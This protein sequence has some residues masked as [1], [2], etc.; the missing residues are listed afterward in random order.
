MSLLDSKSKAYDKLAEDLNAQHQK[1][2]EL[3]RQVSELEQSV[4][5]ANAAASSSKFH[6]QGLQQEIEQLKR[7]NDW[8]DKELKTKSEEYSKYR[9]EKGLRISELQR[10]KED[11][12]G[13]IESLRKTETNL[14]RRLEELSEKTDNAFQKIQQMEEAAARKDES[15]RIELDAAARLQE[16]TRKSANTEQQR[17]QDLLAELEAA[18]D[19]A[20]EQLGKLG[21]E[22]ET[23][24]QEREA[25]EA[26]IAELEVQVEHL[27][28]DLS[29]LGDNR[30]EPTTPRQGVNGLGSRT[31]LRDGA[32][33]GAFSPG[34]A[35]IKGG[36]S[37]T[38]MYS[39]YNDTARQLDAEKRRNETLS[40]TIDAMIQEMEA[41]GPEIEEMQN[42]HG[43][44]ETEVETLSDLVN[45]IGQDRDQATKAV[46][47]WESQVKVKTTEGEVLRQQLRDLS[48]QI[49]VLLMEAHIRNHENGEISVEERARLE[50]IARGE[51]D[52]EVVEGQSA[53]A[54]FINENLVI[55]RD[56][57]GLQE[58]NA[59]LLKI[60]REVGEKLENEDALRKQTEDARNWEDLQ[61][62]YERCKDEIKSLATQSQSYIRERD[63]FRRMLAHRGQIPR[64]AESMFDESINV[65]QGTLEPQ[66]GS[67]IKSTEDVSPS[68]N[69]ADYAKL[70]KD[71]QSHFD[72]YK[73]EAATDNKTL[74]DQLD[75]VSKE[76]S[77]L[78]SEAARSNSQVSLAHERYEMLQS[79]YGMLKNENGELQKRAQTYSDNA[80]KQDLRVQ[81]VAE[82]LVE[83]RG[84]V[85]SMRNETANLKAEKEFWKS[86]EKRITDDNESLLN[87]R[88]RLNS[89]NANLQNLLNEREHSDSDTRRRLHLQ[90]ESLE[91]DLQTTKSKLTEETE[92]NKRSTQRR[93][94]DQEQNQKRIDDLISSLGSVR[95]ELVATKTTRDH[96]SAR[97]DELT[98]EL[99]SAEERLTVLHSAS[100]RDVEVSNVEQQG[101]AGGDGTSHLTQEQELG[102][103][104]S[105][106]KRDLD[107]T[108]SALD[109]AHEQVEQY[110]SISQ[111]S[112]DELNSM[113]E[114][115]DL[116]RQ[117]MEKLIEERDTRIKELEQRVDD[118]SS[119]LASSNDELS[120]LRSEQA[121][122]SRRLEEHKKAF[123]AE[124]ALLKD[125]DDR[126]AAAAQYY[127]E[128]LK[129][130]A[131]IAQ[132]AQ[133]NYE[134]EL[135]K[136]ADAAKAL[137]KVRNDYNIL[138]LE[139][140]EVKT[141]AESAKMNLSQS[142]DSWTDS[143]ERFEREMDELKLARQDLKIQ[144]EFLHKQLETFNTR[145]EK[146]GSVGDEETSQAMMAPG[147]DNLQEVI[148][149]LRREKEIVDV[150]FELSSQEAKRLR[151]QLDYTQSQLDENR[152]KLN[153]Q[154]RIEA[155]NERSALD[156]TKLMDTINDLNT[157]RES[158]VTLRAE[159]R[160]A[161]ATVAARTQEIEALRAQVEP[162]QAQVRELS[163]R[164][165]NYDGEAKLLKENCDRWQQRAQNVLQKYDRVDPADLES[166]KEQLKKAEIERDEMAASKQT[167][168]DQYDN[169]SAQVD[170]E[171]EQS[172]ERV[173]TMKS[174]LTEQFKT[175][176]K[177]LSERIKE[178]DVALQTA[179]TER[180]ELE[181][182]V[183]SL[184]KLQDQLDTATVER[185]A[186]LQR[187]EAHPN[188]TTVTPQS[189]GEDGEVNEN[190]HTP[191]NQEDLQAL[192]KEVEE[193][194]AK[195]KLEQVESSNLRSEA[196]TLKST[197]AVL[198]SQLASDHFPQQGF[199]FANTPQTSSQQRVVALT[200]ELTTLRSTQQQDVQPLNEEAEDQ[201]QKLR[202]DLAQAQR[203]A[204][205][206]RIAASVNATSESRVQDDGS[207]PVADQVA[208]RVS[209]VRAEM[210]ARH[211]ERMQQND[212]AFKLRS[213]NLAAQLSDKL[214]D[215]KAKIRQ[216]LTS[217]HEDFIQNL[218]TEHAQ[219]MEKLQ[220]RHRDEMDELRRVEE[221]K[222]TELK[223]SSQYGDQGQASSESTAAMN[224][225]S[226]KPSSAWQPSEEDIRSLIQ[227]NV[228][229]K[230]ILKNNITKQISKNKEELTAQLKAE[231][232]K[233][234]ADM[235]SKN[236]AAKEHA[237]AL[238][239]KKS[240]LQLN[241]ATNKGK[242]LEFKLGVV[243]KAAQETP[244]KAVQE[245]W[246]VAKDAK[247]SAAPATTPATA[248]TGQTQQIPPQTSTS[249][250]GTGSFGRPTPVPQ[251]AVINVPHNQQGSSSGA[252]TD[253]K[254]TPSSTISETHPSRTQPGQAQ[255][256]GSQPP[257]HPPPR[258]SAPTGPGQQ[259]QNNSA[260]AS[261]GSAAPK[262]LPS[263]IPRGGSMRGNQNPRG[264]N[265]RG[266]GSGIARGAPQSIDTSRAAQAA[267]Q[268]RGS[269]SSAMNAG[270][271]QFVPGNKR[272]SDDPQGGDG[273]RARG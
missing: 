251:P 177:Q 186:A 79:N 212:E 217:E 130:Q 32:S 95:E 164:C 250:T 94:Y 85:E 167:L 38:Q 62:K 234:I 88:N 235:N 216:E 31:P 99:R 208:E 70:L 211:N 231:H 252:P 271:K 263:A 150:Q 163:E 162:L 191:T 47:K 39:N 166:L 220:T 73:Q 158:N 116:Y 128:D 6:E 100:K 173:E 48:S 71:M 229:L 151:Q 147:F 244:Q 104:V 28:A 183:S 254:P 4:Q 63:M 80:A 140:V 197:I 58:Q 2:I 107:L 36:L 199:Q 1:T 61:Q 171:K 184:S 86:I 193:V 269:P 121:E 77:R 148:K 96:L 92:E 168:Q 242:T 165:E 46:K 146:S 119:E 205:N 232:E 102:V 198:Q 76:N 22:L 49:K 200:T 54:R 180:Q 56:L 83:A 91:K 42:D 25:S 19:D 135:V 87:E 125:Q 14:R 60:T 176:S 81:Q 256:P 75:I 50:Q 30:R 20:S 204:E 154:R 133:Q 139:I 129:V 179:M 127:Q 114:T 240:S 265:Q 192:R 34:S 209:I 190:V 270:A 241:M 21:A 18:K 57:S 175:R 187:A 222:F 138:K 65:D 196:A 37:M 202:D 124:L 12:T 136:H 15:F 225:E 248:P 152:L 68:Q 219:E 108:R 115:Q 273:K 41:K 206:L 255:A 215:G 188:A 33:P 27:Q 260:N 8:L 69:M 23:E 238:A 253:N 189:N 110:K 97:V 137:Q 26:R 113:N 258:S 10:Q 181:A 233:A 214:R 159:S 261:T 262:G 117:Q 266:R 9:K 24:H 111:S 237:V 194:G 53:T 174:R 101:T 143:R 203:D 29:V 66:Q 249:G 223:N 67:L 122:Y 51:I 82:D 120:R 267:P 3:R 243:S 5:S 93:E 103:Q 112:E 131:D 89:L 72:A 11:A 185:D 172:N 55:F 210:E 169:I 106:L 64:G 132:Q 221:I 126:H 157:L 78:R 228:Y 109:N 144:N 178:K 161:Q 218:K 224:V 227:N 246:T 259:T 213:K 123:D 257:V 245:V 98:I 142:E 45:E 90:I 59:N 84:L 105:E 195:V 149:Y 153:Q 17:Q 230:N 264:M 236:E 16:L 141:E 43:R 13:E 44:L 268:G 226:Q 156:H 155:D 118:T 182:R 52:E 272:P 35:R 170:Q 239:G 74:K 134:N 145:K 201:L 7:N 160:Q 40:S 247:P 207:K